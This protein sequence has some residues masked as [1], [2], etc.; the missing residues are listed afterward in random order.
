VLG[1]V[2][3]NWLAGLGSVWLDPRAPDLAV[4]GHFRVG[5]ALVV[6]FTLAALVSRRID[7]APRARGA[8]VDRRDGAAALG[9]AGLPGP[10]ADATV[11]TPARPVLSPVPAPARE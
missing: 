6:L 2:I 1:L 10:P 5:T 8:S 4:S 3:L 9:R 7:H 11:T